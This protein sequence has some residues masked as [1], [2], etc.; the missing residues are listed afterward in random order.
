MSLQGLRKGSCQRY[1][2]HGTKP[3]PSYWCWESGVRKYWTFQSRSDSL[4]QEQGQ[5]QRRSCRTTSLA[6]PVKVMP[7]FLSGWKGSFSSQDSCVQ[8]VCCLDAGQVKW[9]S[10]VEFHVTKLILWVSSR[11]MNYGFQLR[12]MKKSWVQLNVWVW[13]TGRTDPSSGG[14]EIISVRLWSQLKTCWVGVGNPE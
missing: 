6:L 9:Y 3:S 10:V 14:G 8:K 1:I 5:P 4:G 2:L 7:Q 11:T 13:G 12:Y